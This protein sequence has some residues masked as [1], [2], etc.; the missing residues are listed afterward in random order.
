MAYAIEWSENAL[1]SKKL[2]LSTFSRFDEALEALRWGLARKP[3]LCPKIKGCSL[4]CITIGPFVV[5]SE[6]VFVV[7]TFFKIVATSKVSREWLES[8]PIGDQE[9]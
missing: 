9:C 4:R 5:P 6:G 2:Y 1:S 7:K 8:C 3:F